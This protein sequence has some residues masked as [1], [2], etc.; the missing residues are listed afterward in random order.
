MIIIQ[1]DKRK[2][3]VIKQEQEHDKIVN[4]FVCINKFTCI[5]QDPMKQH[6]SIIKQV[7]KQCLEHIPKILQH[8][9]TNTQS[10]C[11]SEITGNTNTR[12][13]YN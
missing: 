3:I 10:S 6:Q 8:E 2:T 7:V 9:P 1:A 5:T 4:D 13:T 11:T 12:K